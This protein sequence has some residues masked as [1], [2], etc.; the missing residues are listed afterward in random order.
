MGYFS[1]WTVSK[2]IYISVTVPVTA[3]IHP[4]VP[5]HHRQSF[6]AEVA[7]KPCQSSLRTA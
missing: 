6:S 7:T 1:C 4:D 2:N 5:S 3:D